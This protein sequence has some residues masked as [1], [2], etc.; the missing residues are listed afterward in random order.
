MMERGEASMVVP[1]LLGR[2]SLLWI[3][4]LGDRQSRVCLSMRF[5]S[6]KTERERVEVQG[7]AFSFSVGVVGRW[8][9]GV[10]LFG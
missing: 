1:V 5:E 8:L 7:R 3:L 2:S 9:R 4:L 6:G 10:E